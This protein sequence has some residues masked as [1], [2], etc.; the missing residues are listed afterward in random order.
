MPMMNEFLCTYITMYLFMLGSIFRIFDP[1]CQDRRSVLRVRRVKVSVF[2]DH[3][4]G[5][6][7]EVQESPKSKLIL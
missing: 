4:D 1:W 2:T 5:F 6:P 3:R 7:G